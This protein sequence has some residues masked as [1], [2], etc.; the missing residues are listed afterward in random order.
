ML[1]TGRDRKADPKDCVVIGRRGFSRA[2]QN[3]LCFDSAEDDSR[4]AHG[5]FTYRGNQSE[6]Y[7][8]G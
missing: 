2:G 7:H 8:R 5:G 3:D 4:R 1:M 6:T